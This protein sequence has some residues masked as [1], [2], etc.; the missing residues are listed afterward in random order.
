[1]KIKE[2]EIKHIT[3]YQLCTGYKDNIL[4]VQF[5]FEVVTF[6]IKSRNDH[7]DQVLQ[8]S[9]KIESQAIHKL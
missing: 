8:I 2:I 7:S 4:L 6:Y 5:N 1:V 3:S 9:G